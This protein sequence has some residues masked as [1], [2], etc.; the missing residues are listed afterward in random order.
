MMSIWELS[1]LLCL[2]A[3][4]A[5]A[6]LS[7][8]A[9]RRIPNAL[10]LFGIVLGFLFQTLEP[11]GFGLFARWPGSLG[12]LQGLY[13]LLIGLGV[14]LPLYLMRAMG[15]GDVKLLAM[16]GVW[17]GAKPMF[18]IVMLT[19]LAGGVLA[20]VVALWNR[21]LLS[22]LGNVRFMITD[23]VVRVTSG[24]R[25]SVDAP[26]RTTGRLP[27]AIAIAAGT[28]AEVVLMKGWY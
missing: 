18:G 3:L 17:F 19:L 24:G 7:D 8:L 4:L 2:S 27:Y 16:V 21:S 28:V 26:A 14:F 20:I 5:A 12:F 1:S 15:A 22:T 11:Q 23:S 13:G 10:V 6:V 25:A 9:T